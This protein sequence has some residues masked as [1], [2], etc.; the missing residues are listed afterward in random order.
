M[1]TVEFN[2]KDESIEIFCDREGLEI[3]AKK[4]NILSTKGGHIHLMT[5][6]WA[7][8][9]LSEEKQGLENELVNHLRIVLKP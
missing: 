4:I 2:K 7:G 3:L 9:E 8:S 5:P 1:L 6:S